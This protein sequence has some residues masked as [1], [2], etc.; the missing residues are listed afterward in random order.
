MISAWERHI[1]MNIKEKFL[2]KIKINTITN[3]W[4]WTDELHNKY[5]RFKINKK[6]YRAH[7]VSMHIFKNF[8]LNSELQ[9]NHKIICINKHCVNPNYL[10]IGTQIDNMKDVVKRGG[11]QLHRMIYHKSIVNSHG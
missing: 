9:I 7:R 3:C 6:M 2:N 11:N 10:Y 1:T 4:L 5:G 8:D